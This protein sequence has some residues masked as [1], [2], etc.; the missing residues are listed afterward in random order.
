MDVAGFLI[1]PAETG[2]SNRPPAE[3]SAGEDV[4]AFAL[5]LE[6]IG[7]LAFERAA[8]AVEAHGVTPR[9]QDTVLDKPTT[10]HRG[11][12]TG[13]DA[14][15]HGPDVGLRFQTANQRPA[16]T[17]H[18]AAQTAAR[19]HSETPQPPAPL[20]PP[21]GLPV[22]I[23]PL[24]ANGSSAFTAQ[25]QG[26]HAPRQS[27]EPVSVRPDVTGRPSRTFDPLGAQRPA[28][29]SATRHAPNAPS[30]FAQI[31][32][33]HVGR[34]ETR[35]DVRLD[36]PELGRIDVRYHAQ[37]GDQAHLTLTFEE[38]TT[39]DLFRRDSETLRAFLTEHDI[40][41]ASDQLQF[42]LAPDQDTYGRSTS[43]T[44]YFDVNT[45]H[46]G[47]IA[48]TLPL[49]NQDDHALPESQTGTRLSAPGDGHL[50]DITA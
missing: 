7:A 29:R 13:N 50:I 33:R 11:E 5:S 44:L 2:G 19:H 8:I 42:D 27:Q 26:Q 30:D 46:N 28:I 35:F 10:A 3:R 36:P 9:T 20:T 22:Q 32:A 43:D 6:N 31:V 41:V 25:T 39:R 48:V 17:L 12:A 34:G 40:D 37:E 15:A 1:S 4:Q 24:I 21:S 47:A 38:E 14:D 16:A 45:A 23:S 49:I 18:T